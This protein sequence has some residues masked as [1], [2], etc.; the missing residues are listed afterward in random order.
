MFSKES[1]ADWRKLMI[2]EADK[3][4]YPGVFALILLAICPKSTKLSLVIA[5]PIGV[6]SGKQNFDF[7]RDHA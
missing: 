6:S 5:A 1:H 2:D 3:P 4:E 7:W